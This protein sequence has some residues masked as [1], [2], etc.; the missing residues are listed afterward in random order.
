MPWN[1]TM[2]R[3]GASTRWVQG[4]VVTLLAN[5]ERRR[6]R[7]ALRALDDRLLK[8]IGLTR[9]DVERECGRPYWR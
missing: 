6:Q 1:V 5:E 9:A 2:L 4:L 7:R 8:D 3:R